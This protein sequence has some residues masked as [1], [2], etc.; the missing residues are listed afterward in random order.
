MVLPV[1]RFH[2]I[3]DQRM[4]SISHLLQSGR[5]CI[6]MQ[7][8]HFLTQYVSVFTSCA[9]IGVLVFVTRLSETGNFTFSPFRALPQCYHYHCIYFLSAPPPSFAVLRFQEAPLIRPSPL[10]HLTFSIISLL[11]VLG[12]FHH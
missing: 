9:I 11:P 5:E 12:F 6:Q 8:R 2:H 4:E 3:Q 7:I 10:S 1:S